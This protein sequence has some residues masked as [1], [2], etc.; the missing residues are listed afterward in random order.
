MPLAAPSVP[1]KS[2]TVLI[3]RIVGRARVYW[4]YDRVVCGFVAFFS[5]EDSRAHC[6]SL[7]A[8]PRQ[9]LASEGLS[10]FAEERG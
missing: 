10:S 9:S 3:G 4:S 7:S 6:A 1:M 8:N 5:R 2:W